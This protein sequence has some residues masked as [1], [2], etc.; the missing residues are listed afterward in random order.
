VDQKGNVYLAAGE[1]YVYDPAG[2]PIQTINT[3]ERPIGLAFGGVDGKTLFI[4]GRTSLYAVRTQFAGQSASKATT[5]ATT[6]S[7]P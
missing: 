3:P 7:K 6:R 4:L 5:R 2:K 1:V